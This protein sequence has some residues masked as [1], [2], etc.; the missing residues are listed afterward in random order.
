MRG[1]Q[2]TWTFDEE[3]VVIDYA[4]GWLASSLNKALARTEVPLQAVAGVDFRTRGSGA[5]KKGW[6]MRL[7]IRD[8]ADP[9]A[10]VGAA[11]S[12]EDPFL[13]SGDAKTELVAEYHADQ[14]RLL[15]EQAAAQG[16]PPAGTPARLVAP[17]PLHIQVHEGTAAFD[18]SSLVLS[19]TSE[20]AKEKRSAQRREFPLEQIAK[21]EWNPSDGWDYGVLRVL[22]EGGRPPKKPVPAKRDLTCLLFDEGGEQAQALLMA[23]TVT[24]HLWAA[25]TG[26]PETAEAPAALGRGEETPAIG[27]GADADDDIDPESRIVMARIRKLGEL[28]AEGL[29]TDEEFSAKKAELLERL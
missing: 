23:A 14:L 26:R 4:T 15:A 27:A 25:G 19:W 18:G 17:L 7:R 6:E 21:V 8:Q 29:L 22:P 3:K 5:K 24:A 12:G 28:H 16:A 1:K 2:G 10:A 13:L 20:A 9:F 11:M